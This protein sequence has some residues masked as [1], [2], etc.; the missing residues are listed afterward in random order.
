MDLIELLKSEYIS[1]IFGGIAGILTAWVTQR[2]LHKRGVFRY[3]V[4]HNRI[5][6]SANDNIFGN[7]QIIW[8]ETNL[9]DLYLST[10]ELRND[11]L[12]DYEDVIVHTFSDNTNL[13][14]ERTGISNSPSILEF[15]DR[16]KQLLHVPD[17][18]QIT[19]NQRNIYFGQR[20][21]LVPILN[22]GETVS[23]TY[24]NT[25]KSAEVPAI[26]LSCEKKG[27]KV[28]YSEPQKQIFGVSQLH[29]VL[30]GIIIGLVGLI[31]A[32]IYT[33]NNWIVVAVAFLYGLFV[34]VPG[35][36]AIKGIRKFREIIGG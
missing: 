22:R 13:L 5:G 25:P 28:K 16:Y 26:W 17:G 31:P 9:Q 12:N 32:M 15:T 27:V 3:F 4:E 33:T 30:Y 6:M 14:T 1:I 8:N 11:S 34:T 7:V 35:A 2:V 20:E 24:L 19:D 23:L 36:L 10:I 29:A 21:Y 18:Q